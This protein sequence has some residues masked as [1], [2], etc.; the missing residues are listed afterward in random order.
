LVKGKKKTLLEDKT[1]QKKKKKKKENLMS[2]IIN[3]L[4]L[5]ASAK[6]EV[7]YLEIF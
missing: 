2:N 7:S 4:P 1:I 5:E 6:L 3:S